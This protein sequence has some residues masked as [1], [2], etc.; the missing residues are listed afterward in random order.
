MKVMQVSDLLK[1]E[2][3]EIMCLGINHDAHHY[4]PDSR[5]IRTVAEMP[6]AVFE[7]MQRK[8]LR[9]AA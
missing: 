8:L 2:G 7:M 4:F 6:H 9:K 3:I 5:T 1:A